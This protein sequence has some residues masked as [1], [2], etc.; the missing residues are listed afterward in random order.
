MKADARARARAARVPFQVG[1][2]SAGG[3]EFRL[4]VSGPL[5]VEVVRDMAAA[6]VGHPARHSRLLLDQRQLE[7]GRTLRDYNVQ[8]GALLT[9]VRLEVPFMVVVHWAYPTPL[10]ILA[11]DTIHNVKVK[12]REAGCDI[13][14]HSQ[15]LTFAGRVLEDDR[16][17]GDY[18]IQQ[19]CYLD[20]QRKAFIEGHGWG[21]VVE[22]RPTYLLRLRGP[23]TIKG[24]GHV[25]WLRLW[26]ADTIDSIKAVI[27]E[28]EGI[29]PEQQRLTYYDVELEAGNTLAHYGIFDGATIKCERVA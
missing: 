26:G 27:T 29:P 19:G 12:I 23:D 14:P 20:V 6:Q 7:D 8:P 5:L 17:V 24:P 4:R 28:E 21:L 18:N 15:H 1:V 13:A 9:F 2:V 16:E 25:S 10:D 3:A 22:R 11:S